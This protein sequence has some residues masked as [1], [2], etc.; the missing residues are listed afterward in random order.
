M[1]LSDERPGIDQGTEALLAREASHEDGTRGRSPVGP[2]LPGV[3]GNRD[4]IGQV[5]NPGGLI[6]CADELPRDLLGD[7]HERVRLPAPLADLA[8]EVAPALP[9]QVPR[10][11]R[12]LGTEHDRK[13]VL[14]TRA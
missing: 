1:S 3:V 10:R 12:P 14:S 9:G 4:A 11:P 5:V 13:A 6:S 8:A 7:G 2:A